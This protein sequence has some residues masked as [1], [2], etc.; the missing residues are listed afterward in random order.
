MRVVET[1]IKEDLDMWRCAENYFMKVLIEQ[2]WFI[3]VETSRPRWSFKDWD[4]QLTTDDWITT[5]EVKYDILSDRT[6]NIAVEI[7]SYW[8]PSWVFASKANY[9][10]YFA[11]NEWRY[12]DRIEFIKK[13]DTVEKELTRWWDD[14]QTLFYLIKKEDAMKILKKFDFNQKIG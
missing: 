3:S 4:V 1:E 7:E 5:F 2:E 14:N 10:V 12:Q 8:K 13:L 11:Y 9:I 6:G